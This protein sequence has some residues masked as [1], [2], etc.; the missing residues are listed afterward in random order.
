M[1]PAAG[2][3]ATAA[4]Q[5]MNVPAGSALYTLAITGMHCD[6][7][8]SGLKSELARVPGVSRAEVDLQKAQARVVCDTNRVTLG[9]ILAA[10]EE[11]GF[12]GNTVDR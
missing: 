7:C 8:A 5:A 2:P 10:V 3:P 4:E 11:A 12:K 6:G 1:N 9:Q